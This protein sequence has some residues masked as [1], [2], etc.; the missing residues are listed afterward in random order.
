MDPLCA[1]F[2]VVFVLLFVM[3]LS[4]VLISLF[5][6]FFMFLIDTLVSLYGGRSL[7]CIEIRF[8]FVEGQVTV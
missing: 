7:Y 6:V 1:V 8:S 4:G 3:F 5:F 2:N